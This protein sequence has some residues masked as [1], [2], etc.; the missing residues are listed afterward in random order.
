MYD[1]PI[2]DVR[3]DPPGPGQWMGS[4]DHWAR[5]ITPIL[6]S[7][8]PRAFH[9]GIAT[10]FEDLGLALRTL[11]MQ[12]VNGIAYI[13]PVGIVDN[14]GGKTPPAW[15][16]KLVTRTHPAFRASASGA[17]RKPS[18]SI[19][20]ASDSAAGTTPKRR[21]SCSPTEPARRSTSPT[22]RRK[23][24]W[25]SSTVASLISRTDGKPTSSSARSRWRPSAGCSWRP[26]IVGAS[27]PRS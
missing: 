24:W 23:R 4:L 13:R 5:P 19:A 6:G 7:I 16:L 10:T 22:S 3:W 26:R 1:T 14:P 20:G 25:T 11:D 21:T 2:A 17:P 18:N 15:V 27:L 8:A 9:A 12:L